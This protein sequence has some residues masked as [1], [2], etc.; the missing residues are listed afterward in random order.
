MK[1]FRERLTNAHWFTRDT[2]IETMTPNQVSLLSFVMFS[3]LL[4]LTHVVSWSGVVHV[5]DCID[6]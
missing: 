1:L 6:S 5:L 3:R 2:A 4:S